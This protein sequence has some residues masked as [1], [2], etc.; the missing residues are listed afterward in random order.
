MA[1]FPLRLP[2]TLALGSRPCPGPGGARC[3]GVQR[4]PEIQILGRLMPQFS[5]ARQACRQVCQC[6]QSQIPSDGQVLP[7]PSDGQVLPAAAGA[8]RCQCLRG[9]RCM[10]D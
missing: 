5:H 4:L 3:P 7:V 10:V 6:P 1:P 2:Q 8:E 9:Q